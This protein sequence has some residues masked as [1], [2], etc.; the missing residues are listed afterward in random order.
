MKQCLGTVIPTHSCD[1]LQIGYFSHN[2][3]QT[4][5]SSTGW[6]DCGLQ[7]EIHQCPSICACDICKQ[8][9]KC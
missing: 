6:R 5:R 4:H 8:N 1:Y 2:V 3:R 7:W 9:T